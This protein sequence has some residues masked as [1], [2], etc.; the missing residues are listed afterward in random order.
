M[1][2][3][4]VGWLAAQHDEGRFLSAP[5][6]WRIAENRW[7]ALRDGVHGTLADLQSGAPMDTVHRLHQLLDKIEPH[8]PTGLDATRASSPTPAPTTSDGSES[9]TPWAPWSNGSR[10]EPFG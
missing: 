9:P 4:L 2:H 10:H 1:V 6:T 5:I 3:S 7:N 8:A